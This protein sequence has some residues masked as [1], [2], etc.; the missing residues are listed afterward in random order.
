MYNV[1]VLKKTGDIKKPNKILAG[2]KE[3]TK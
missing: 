3:K 1:I 2:I